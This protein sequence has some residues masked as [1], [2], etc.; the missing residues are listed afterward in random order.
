LTLEEDPAAAVV[1]DV[2]NHQRIIEDFAAAIRERR[3][4]ICDARQGRR[5]VA[6]VEAIYQSARE[7]RVVDVSEAGNR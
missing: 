1:S 6:V 5:S 7:Q 3:P 2:S 4:P